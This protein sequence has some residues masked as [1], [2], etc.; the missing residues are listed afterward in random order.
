M[1]MKRDLIDKILENIFSQYFDTF[2][3][4]FL[5]QGFSLYIMLT[6][7]HTISFKHSHALQNGG[8]KRKNSHVKNP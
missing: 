6:P 3:L 8:E 2:F 1:K 7:I 5:T 4:L